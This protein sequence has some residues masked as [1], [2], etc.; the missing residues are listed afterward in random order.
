MSDWEA[1]RDEILARYSEYRR[2]IRDWNNEAVDLDRT[3]E[4]PDRIEE[5]A[6]QLGMVEGGTM[7]F[8]SEHEMSILRD[9]VSFGF[10]KR[11]ERLIDVFVENKLKDE[12]LPDRQRELL[13]NRRRDRFVI[14]EIQRSVQGLGVYISDVLVG[15][16]LF[17]VDRN[18]SQT[19]EIGDL[20]AARLISV[21]DWWATTGAGF[22]VDI[23]VIQ[24]VPRHLRNLYRDKGDRPEEIPPV[25]RRRFECTLV[26]EARRRGLTTFIETKW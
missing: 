3:L 19:A 5:F 20:F 2:W 15:D 23:S 13:R 22:P 7:V 25:A 1:R 12:D 6:R 26:R 9:F 16:E 11:G 4:G 21:E 17:I 14:F 10:P 8:E 18:L 24:S